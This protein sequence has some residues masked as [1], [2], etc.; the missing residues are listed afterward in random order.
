MKTIVLLFLALAAGVYALLF[1]QPGLY[2]SRSLEYRNFRL[3][4]RG[5]PPSGVEF[6]L[7]HA[8]ER[9]SGSELYAPEQRFDVYLAGSP[10]EFAFFTPLMKYPRVRLNPFNGA[11]FLASADFPADRLRREASE[12]DYRP[13]GAVLAGAAARELARRSM[14]P[15]KYLFMSEWRL[16]GYAEKISGGSGLFNPPDI[17]AG[18]E[19]PELQAFEYG[20]AV[21]LVLREE[22]MGYRELLDKSYSYDLVRRRLK[23]NVCGR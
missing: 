15:L 23:E 14:E 7:D 5:Q 4:S 10:A 19:D 6:A 12:T 22:N 9:L 20:L 3:H 16:G 1:F 2:F 13:L 21:D 11:I 18:R 8:V 17:C